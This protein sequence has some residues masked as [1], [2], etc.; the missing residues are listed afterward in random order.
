MYCSSGDPYCS[1]SI[2]V[3]QRY[4]G[5]LTLFFLFVCYAT[6]KLFLVLSNKL[7]L[8]ATQGWA[9]FAVF[10]TEFTFALSRRS[11][12]GR[13]AKHLVQWNLDAKQNKNQVN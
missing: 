13:V 5:Q 12:L 11:Q 6:T 4:A 1:F 8:S 10:H 9:V 3:F 2:T 7:F